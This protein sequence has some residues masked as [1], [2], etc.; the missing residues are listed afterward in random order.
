MVRQSQ[1]SFLLTRPLAQSQRFAH[2]LIGDVVISPLMAP[3]FL[4]PKIAQKP[5]AAM[6]F[7]SETG[8]QAAAGL[9]V[10]INWNYRADDDTMLEAGEDFGEDP[11]SCVFELVEVQAPTAENAE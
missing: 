3:E 11:E 10:K 4:R 7:T 6:I 2:G 8:V 5:Y 9:A 1:A